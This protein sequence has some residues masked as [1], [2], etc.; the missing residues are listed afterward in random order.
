[1]PLI[2][3]KIQFT[4]EEQK[5][6]QSI[7]ATDCFSS[8]DW[9]VDW[10]MEIRSKIRAFY[11]GEQ[12]GICC[13]C[14]NDVS[15][16]SAGNAHIEHIAPKSLYPQFMFEPKN[17]CVV[18]CDCNEIKRNKEVIN[19]ADDVF[20]NDVVRYPTASRA[21][22]IVHPHVDEY[23]EHIIKRGRMYLDRSDKGAFTIAT[24]KLNR[25][26]HKFDRESPKAS[27]SDLTNLMNIFM[28]SD[29]SI[30]KLNALQQLQD[31]LV[32][33]CF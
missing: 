16:V 20:S 7:K 5:Q 14:K 3:N 24:C 30:D 8:S 23:D 15:Q 12:A 28:D 33:K 10:L 2:N 1:M 9:G 21:F 18:C 25:F 11:R 22:K 26:F 6:L 29:S 17:L 13:Y 32:N 4:L 31:E 27:D 19:E